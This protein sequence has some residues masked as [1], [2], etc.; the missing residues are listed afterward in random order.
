MEKASYKSHTL[1]TGLAM[2][3]MLFGAG[4]IVF[5]LALGQHAQDKNLFAILGLLITAVGV[6]FIGLI[7]MA[8]FEGDYK[9]FFERMGKIPGFATASI[10]LALIGPFGAL[11]RCIALSFSTAKLYMPM[12]IPLSC[13]SLIACCF[14][15]LFALKRTKIIDILGYV[16]T[17]ILLSSLFIIIVTGMM[18]SPPLSPSSMDELSL[19]LQGLKEGY[20]TMDLLGTFFF[21]SVVLVCLKKDIET[22]HSGNTKKIL[23]LTMKASCIGASLLACIYIGFSYIAASYSSALANIT[24]DALIAA[25]SMQILG[26]YAGIIVCMAVILACLTTAIALANVFAEFL[27]KDITQ[28]KLNY[29]F[30]LICTLIVSFIIST[31][32][33]NGIAQVLA[34]ILQIGYP[35][36][37]T[38]S[39]VNILYV[40]YNFQPVKIPVLLVFVISLIGYFI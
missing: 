16:L 26:P 8:L 13:F 20:Q 10:I 36:L 9:R 29:K 5:P 39:L 32:N 23:L 4:N 28:G 24:P 1:A 3:S 6:P 18:I 33:F 11:P 31:L 7:A 22:S 2:F 37:I 30:S 14:I 12:E 21:C 38:L 35:A 40:I 27:H 17:P 25:I 19:F 34:P 15:F